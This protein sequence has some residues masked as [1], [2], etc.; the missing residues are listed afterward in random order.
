MV[1][2]GSSRVVL[3]ALMLIQ[4]FSRMM[5]FG[6]PN[7]KSPRRTKGVVSQRPQIPAPPIVVSSVTEHTTRNFTPPR[8]YQRDTQG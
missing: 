7:E 8:A 3:V 5:G 2:F 6:S 4:L 1:L